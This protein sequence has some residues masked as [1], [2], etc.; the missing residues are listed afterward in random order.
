LYHLINQEI[1]NAKAGKPAAIT[2]KLNSFSDV[3]LIKKL[4]ITN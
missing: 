3:D 4:N 2:I 1:K